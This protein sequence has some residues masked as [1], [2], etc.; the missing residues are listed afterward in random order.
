MN[1]LPERLYDLIRYIR[2]LYRNLARA[3]ESNLTD[4]PVSVGMRAILEIVYEQGPCSVP[5]IADWMGTGRQYVQRMVNDNLAE[6]TL[7]KKPN[8]AHRRSFLLALT[9]LGRELFEKIR[10]REAQRL[11]EVAQTIRAE[12]L[13]TCLGVVD[14]LHRGFLDEDPPADNETPPCYG[15]A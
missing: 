9:P 7:E 3:V 11:V 6:G 15:E 4:T 2:P 5:Q 14:A 1:A 13:E 12:D 8:P 10:A